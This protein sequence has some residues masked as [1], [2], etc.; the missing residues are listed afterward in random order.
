[1]YWVILIVSFNIHVLGIL[2]VSF[3]IHVLGILIVSLIYMY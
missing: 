2:I 1:M 3:N